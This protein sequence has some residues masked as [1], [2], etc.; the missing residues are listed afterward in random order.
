[1]EPKVSTTTWAIAQ[2][3]GL[4]TQPCKVNDYWLPSQRVV[5]CLNSKVSWNRTTFEAKQIFTRVFTFRGGTP[6][7]SH[8]LCHSCHPLPLLLVQVMVFYKTNCASLINIEGK[9]THTLESS[10]AYWQH[11]DITWPLQEP[12]K[13]TNSPKISQ[14]TIDVNVEVMV[15]RLFLSFLTYAWTRILNP[16]FASTSLTCIAMAFLEVFVASKNLIITWQGSHLSF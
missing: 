10:I 5:M 11:F 12:T 13:V 16:C 15:V 3:W 1:M 2:T 14:H 4:S 9:P 6:A 8:A 7:N